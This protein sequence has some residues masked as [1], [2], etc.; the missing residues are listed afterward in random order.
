[1]YKL[2]LF[3]MEPHRLFEKA[4]RQLSCAQ[5]VQSTLRNAPRRVHVSISLRRHSFHSITHRCFLFLKGTAQGIS[6]WGKMNG[7][8]YLQCRSLDRKSRPLRFR[9]WH[10]CVEVRNLARVR[11][12]CVFVGVLLPGNVDGM[13]QAKNAR[14]HLFTIMIS[15]DLS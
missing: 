14:K 11:P 2:T 5:R 6:Y 3:V 12:L 7:S 13:R 9:F 10:G 8:R 1:M 15:V 4:V